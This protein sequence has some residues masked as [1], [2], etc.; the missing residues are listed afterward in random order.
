MW[1]LTQ[2][3]EQK[4][5]RYRDVDYGQGMLRPVELSNEAESA[6]SQDD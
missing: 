3:D 2:D 6:Q 4:N 5:D 1:A